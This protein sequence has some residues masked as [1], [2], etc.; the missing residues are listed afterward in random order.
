MYAAYL[1]FLY[2]IIIC[3][4][5]LDSYTFFEKEKVINTNKNQ[6]LLK[7]TIIFVMSSMLSSFWVIKNN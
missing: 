2:K 7:N 4:I 6:L 1:D 3:K 5:K